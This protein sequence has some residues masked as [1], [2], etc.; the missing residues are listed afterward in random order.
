MKDRIILLFQEY[1]NINRKENFKG[2]DADIYM[3]DCIVDDFVSTDSKVSKRGI[4]L[5]FMILHNSDIN[6]AVMFC[7]GLTTKDMLGKDA[8]EIVNC[9]NTTTK[10]G[11][12][13]LDKDGDVNWEISFDSSAVEIEDVG[14]YISSCIKGIIKIAELVSER[15]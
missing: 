1:G 10:F 2:I 8:Y 14:N 6:H 11:K 5:N 3:F 13:I 12:F 9:A 4:E 7:M 15:N